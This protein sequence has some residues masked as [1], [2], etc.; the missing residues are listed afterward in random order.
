MALEK[1]LEKS[2]LQYLTYNRIFAFKVNNTGIYDPI[3]KIWRKPNSPYILKGVSDILGVLPSGKF[4][5][6]EVKAPKRL[7]TLTEHQKLFLRNVNKNGGI[8]FAADS[9]ELV[10]EKLKDYLMPLIV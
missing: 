4:L 1:Q 6:I 2:I 10:Q 3:K 9:I 7:N 5:A 8:G